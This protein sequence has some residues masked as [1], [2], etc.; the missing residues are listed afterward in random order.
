MFR[1]FFTTIFRGF[2]A[3]LCGVTI[4]PADLRSLSTYCYS[5]CGRMCM[6]S[7][8]VWCSCLLAICLFTS[9]SPTD[10]NTKHTQFV[11]QITNRQEHQ[12]HTACEADYQQTRTPNTH[13]LWSRS[14]THK[15]TKHTQLV[16]Q[17]TNT[18]KHQTHTACEADH[19]QTKTPNTHSLW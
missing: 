16:K 2:S 11:K 14:P 7:V 13:S 8:R 18:Q 6:S 12:T 3:V 15:N 1:S 9:R 17:I 4:P 10:K 19:Q 5:V